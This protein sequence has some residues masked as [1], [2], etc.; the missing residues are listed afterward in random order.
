MLVIG[1]SPAP[2]PGFIFVRTKLVKQDLRGCSAPRRG[3]L[4]PRR[5][6]NQNAAGGTPDP[7]LS[8]QSVSNGAGALPLNEKILRGSDLYRVSRPASAVALLKGYMHLFSCVELPAA[9]GAAPV[10]VNKTCKIPQPKGLKKENTNNPQ[11]EGPCRKKN[12]NHSQPEGR[13]PKCGRPPHRLRGSRRPKGN[14]AATELQV[15]S[16]PIRQKQGVR[17]LPVAFW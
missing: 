5:Q 4:C 11:T 17:G 10:F 8:N 9:V 16:R 1:A 15:T 3:L 7:V 6:S 13:Q 12:R 2:N 14:S